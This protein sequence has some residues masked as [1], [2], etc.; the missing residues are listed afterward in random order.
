MLDHID[1]STPPGIDRTHAPMDRSALAAAALACADLLDRLWAEAMATVAGAQVPLPSAA[2][3][4]REKLA[5]L[6]VTHDAEGH[7]GPATS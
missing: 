3:A 2:G 5:A 4:A 6:A 7:E 1:P